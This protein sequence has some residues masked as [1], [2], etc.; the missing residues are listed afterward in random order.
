MEPEERIVDYAL[1]RLFHGQPEVDL[2][3]AVHRTWERG[4]PGPSLDDLDWEERDWD[5]LDR[6]PRGT[7]AAA[8]NHSRPA[9]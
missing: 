5:A 6:E 3:A 1:L 4:V 8:K 2:S 9:G 7:R